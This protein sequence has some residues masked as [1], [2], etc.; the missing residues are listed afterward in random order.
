MTGSDFEAL[1]AGEQT[2]RL[3]RLA[4]AALAQWPGGWSI[5]RLI[6]YRENAVFE[7]AATDGARAVLRVH[8]NGYHDDA[9]LRSELLWMDALADAGVA[10]PAL[11]R[12]Q[13]GA[14]FVKATQPEVPDERQLDIFRWIDAAPVAECSDA[15]RLT[16]LYFEAGRLAATIHAQASAWTPPRDFRRH[17]WDLE[18]LIGERPL[19]GDYH[20]LPLLTPAQRDQLDRARAQ[21]KHDLQALEG[22][23]FGL[24]HADF[25]PD[26]LLY[27]ADGLRI[28]DFDDC[29]FGWHMFE[30]ATALF[31]HLGEPHYDAIAEA[32]LAG[33]RSVL[34]LPDERWAQLPLF[35][36]VRSLT[37]LGWVT[38]RPE[39]E[40]AREMTGL[41][42]DRAL[43][44]ANAYSAAGRRN[45]DRS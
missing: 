28:I 40:T 35:L 8:R 3:A 12:S 41:L 29:G 39:T 37:Y 14:P 30:L 45:P 22:E 26:N 43:E 1:S 9:S 13:H 11:V 4:D 2:E 6:K 18:G 32:L 21:A 16:D 31:F 34:D 25:V 33:Y 38:S 42:V 5:R 17:R 23:A 27:N 20:S 10:V 7:I 19:W 15:R 44:L 24:I 36:F